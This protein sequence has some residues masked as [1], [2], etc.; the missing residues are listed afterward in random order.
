[1]AGRGPAANRFGPP[2]NGLVDRHHPALTSNPPGV[3]VT[4]FG[5]ALSSEE[6]RPL[7]LVHTAVRAEEVGFDFAM[8]SDHVHPW[9]DRQGQSPFAWAV[10]GGIATST[11][12]LQ[13]GTGVTCPLVRYH[14]AIIAQAAATVA[15]MMP[16][17]FVLGV[18]TGENLN[19]HVVGQ[20]WPETETR[21]E[22]L[23]EAVDII[24]LLWSGE[25]E[26]YQGAHYTIENMRVYTLPDEPPPIVIA[27]SGPKA[28]RFAGAAGDGLCCTAPQRELVE[29]F[30]EAGIER[31][32]RYGQVTVCWAPD[33]DAAV[34]TALEW[35][36]NAAIPG[37][38]S[39]EL[40]LP[41]HFEAL[42]T[43]VTAERIQE[44]IACGPDPAAALQQARA[45]IDAGFDHVYFHQVGP[46]QEGFLRFFEQEL[47]PAL[48]AQAVGAAAG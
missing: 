30:E 42:A 25:N 48:R 18:G 11:S 12:R 9:I 17:R 44:Q 3:P 16:R 36:P 28:A 14:P 37:A 13:V 31:K 20:G 27:A 22:M 8:L 24:R 41:E 35:W 2:R 29:A 33:H 4:S 46:D 15:D 10:L 39:T 1:M 32:P 34:Q 45:F 5:I 26:S 19:E 7:D 23:A 38:A 6:H 43:L 21:L 40:P 47:G